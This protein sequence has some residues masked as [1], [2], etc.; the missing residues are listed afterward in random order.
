LFSSKVADI[1]TI[2][3]ALSAITVA[4][5]S[6]VTQ[7]RNQLLQQL[8]SPED[9]EI[10]DWVRIAAEGHRI[11]P[12]DAE[13]VIVE[14]GDYECP[15]CRR[16]EGPLQALRRAF[17]DEVAVV[18]R[19]YPLGGHSNAY[20]G[21]RYAECSAD[22]NR[23]VEMHRLLFKAIT[24]ED[25]DP[26]K[27]AQTVHVPDINRFKECVAEAGTHP[28]IERDITEAKRIGIRSV[29]T[30][31]LEGR[32]LGTPPDSAGL[33]ELVRSHLEEAPGDRPSD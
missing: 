1:A 22:Q 21:A 25:L 4:G 6:L 27:V 31:I 12:E 19:H 24:L 32:L 7:H 2:L 15:F 28:R 20:L 33:F 9:R 18:F 10:P 5:S 23:F 11:G 17:P 26:E 3:V 8:M 13:V 14:F 30:L 29:P 16:A